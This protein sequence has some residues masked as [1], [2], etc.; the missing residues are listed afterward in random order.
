MRPATPDTAAEF[1]E[2]LGRRGHE[3]LLGQASGTA[4]FDVVDGR[5]THRWLVTI[6]KGDL[7]VSRGNAA[8]DCVLRADKSLFDRIAAG[9]LNFMA[10]V[11]RGEIAVEGD[12]RLLVLL[13]RLA[14]RPSG[15]SRSAE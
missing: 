11:L 9:R 1:F 10:A 8:A 5:R 4:R 13:Q 7:A 15:S 14:P 2:A 12:P 6:D 3:P